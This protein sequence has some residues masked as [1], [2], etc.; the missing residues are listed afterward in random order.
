MGNFILFSDERLGFPPKS[1]ARPKGRPRKF[2]LPGGVLFDGGGRWGSLCVPF[3]WFR[4]DCDKAKLA[5][6]FQLDDVS[7]V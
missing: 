1:G 4:R 2:A 5:V 7:D 6:E 3:G